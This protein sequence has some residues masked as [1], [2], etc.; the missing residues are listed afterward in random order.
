[1]KSAMADLT[2]GGKEWAGLVYI[3]GTHPAAAGAA[4]MTWWKDLPES[5]QR[6]D[7][8]CAIR[9]CHRVWKNWNSL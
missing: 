3:G 4:Y 1:M 6:T 5:V 8:W 7:D 2:E 9:I